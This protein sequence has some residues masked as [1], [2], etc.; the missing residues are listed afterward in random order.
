[1]DLAPSRTNEADVRA[2]I[3]DTGRPWH[4]S[5]VRLL[6]QEGLIL[7]VE[8]RAPGEFGL[9]PVY[10]ALGGY[11][12]ANALLSKLGRDGFAAWIG[13]SA[14]LRAFEGDYQ[15]LH[16]LSTD[17]FLSLAGLLPRR[18]NGEQ[19]WKAL[20]TGLRRSALLAAVRLKMSS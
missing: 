19:L 13:D 4:E 16:P 2:G 10:D 20:H 3:D 6:E 17:I 5:I 15:E 18:L 9:M 14:N 1:M 7:R 12:V 8:G 11:F